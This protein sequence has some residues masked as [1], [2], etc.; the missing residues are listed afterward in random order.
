MKPLNLNATETKSLLQNNEETTK[1]QI[2][3]ME[4][5]DTNSTL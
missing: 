2:E 5:L 4:S 1:I 3:T